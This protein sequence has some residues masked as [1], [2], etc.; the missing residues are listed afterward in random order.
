[1]TGIIKV[2]GATLATHSD[3]TGFV[4]LEPSVITNAGPGVRPA[5][6][7]LSTTQIS[8]NNTNITLPTG[9]K[10]YRLSGSNIHFVG[11]PA[12]VYGYLRLYPRYNG[13]DD[14][15][16]ES[17]YRMRRLDSGGGG[18][19]NHNQYVLLADNLGNDATDSCTFDII[20][21]SLTISGRTQGYN[22]TYNSAYGHNGSNHAYAFFGGAYSQTTTVI[23]DL[24][25]NMY[26]YAGGS[27]AGYAG[28]LVLTGYTN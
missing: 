14:T 22:M 16:V 5:E 4:T 20:L 6:V 15:A 13:T 11:G 9:Y 3:S 10:R 7:W 8:A 23:D 17:G 27:A 25:F 19:A 21:D 26:D 28:E 12:S 24:R 1:M 18:D 2:G